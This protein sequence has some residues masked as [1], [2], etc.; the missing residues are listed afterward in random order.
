MSTSRKPNY[1]LAGTPEWRETQRMKP[2]HEFT[3]GEKAFIKKSLTSKREDYVTGTRFQF[4]EPEP[5]ERRLSMISFDLDDETEQTD[6]FDVPETGLQ[7][8]P[9]RPGKFKR[10]AKKLYPAKVVGGAKAIGGAVRHPMVAGRKVN[11]FVRRKSNN[12]QDPSG[13]ISD[14]RQS[15]AEG[16]PPMARSMTIT[17]G[18]QGPTQSSVSSPSKSPI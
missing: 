13:P 8:T 15:L 9:R 4:I 3:S 10:V 11:R 14:R 16:L 7:A 17:I 5:A 2:I 1:T 12:G 18:E 6:H